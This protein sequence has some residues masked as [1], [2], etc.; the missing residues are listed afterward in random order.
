MTTKGVLTTL[1]R[2]L[3]VLLY[4]L[5][6]W[7]DRLN[8]RCRMHPALDIV[9]ICSVRVCA[10]HAAHCVAVNLLLLAASLPADVLPL[11]VGSCNLLEL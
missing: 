6:R 4:K 10:G 3:P 11:P 5:P 7:I 1:P 8:I 2:W 9:L